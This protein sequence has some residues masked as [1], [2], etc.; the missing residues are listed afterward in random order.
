LA[1]QA[2]LAQVTRVGAT[3]FHCERRWRVLLRDI[4]RFGTATVFSSY[5]DRGPGQALPALGTAQGSR[6]SVFVVLQRGQARPSRVDRSLVRVIGIIRQS[7]A[8]LDAQPRTVLL[9]HWLER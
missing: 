6:W 2:G 8:A 5:V 4:F 1:P 7:R 9:A 3:A